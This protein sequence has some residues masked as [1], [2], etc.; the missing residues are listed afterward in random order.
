MDK[1]WWAE[2]EHTRTK[3]KLTGNAI[4]SLHEDLPGIM[5]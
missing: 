5:E 1:E 4:S 2:S 3:V